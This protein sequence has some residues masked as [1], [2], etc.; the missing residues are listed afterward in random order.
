M[1]KICK[2]KTFSLFQNP[3]YMQVPVPIDPKEKWLIFLDYLVVIYLFYVDQ[4][5]PNQHST[6][7][8][9]KVPGSVYEQKYT[10]ALMN[11]HCGRAG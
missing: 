2:Y 10:I 1:A 9:E 11:K 8:D 7:W 5:P 6:V 4:Y 3:F